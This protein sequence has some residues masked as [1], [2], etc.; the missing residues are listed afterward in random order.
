MNA[1]FV[2]PSYGD[3]ESFLIL[4]RHLLEL[5]PE[6]GID[7]A[8]F[9]LVDD[10][11][12][13]D[14]EVES[15]RSLDDVTVLEAPFNLGHQRAIVFA[16]RKVL[17]EI[18]DQDFVIT[19][20]AD[21]EDRPEDVPRLLAP[22]REE[23]DQAQKVALALRTSRT[24]S[25]QFK[26]MYWLFRLLFRGLT[27]TTV[28]SGN[29][30]AMR[31]GVARRALR[32]P[33]FDLSYSSTLLALDLPIAYVPCPRGAR[34]EGE[35]KMTFGR[36]ST[37]GL[38]M[39][40]PFTDRIA[41]RALAAFTFFLVLG[42]AIAA[43]ILIIRLFTDSAIPGWASMMALVSLII[44]LVALGNF[45]TLFMLFSQTRAVSLSSIEDLG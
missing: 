38:R 36:L 14:P 6:A 24:E 32:H 8:R 20:D 21:G 18:G 28:R 27:G 16:L 40:M 43:T 10:T 26:V 19:L 33:L 13:Q 42:V 35:S 2:T 34:Y 25:V 29:F 45:V 4:R 41:V 31:G 39:L 17:P 23:E 3:V 22:L 1:C 5:A 11:A 9:V 44:S 37:H 7:R 15:L 12:G 30:A